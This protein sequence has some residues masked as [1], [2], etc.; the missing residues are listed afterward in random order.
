M[1]LRPFKETRFQR[2][3]RTVVWPWFVAHARQVIF[4]AV[5]WALLTVIALMI[6]DELDSMAFG[7]VGNVMS[8]VFAVAYFTIWYAYR[9]DRSERNY[10]LDKQAHER[11]ART[12][13]I[14][15]M[16]SAMHNRS[17]RN[18]S[19]SGGS[20]LHLSPDDPMVIEGEVVD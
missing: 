1:S 19:H 15:D 20:G 4:V 13:E 3:E 6:A 16:I 11:N 10:R 12:Q 7:I 9:C 14:L 5:V 2:Y 8:G 17:S 18:R